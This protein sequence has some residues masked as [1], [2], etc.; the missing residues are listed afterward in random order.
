MKKK[1]TRILIS[2]CVVAMLMTCIGVAGFADDTVTYTMKAGDNVYSVCSRLGIDFNA[3]QAWITSVNN[4]TN[5]NNLKVGKVLILPTFNTKT[6]VTRAAQ[7]LANLKGNSNA[8]TNTNTNTNTGGITATGLMSGDTIVSYLVNHV[9]QSGQTVAGVCSA[10]GV[11]F[12]ANSDKIKTLSG[13]TSW[14]KIPV[15]TTVVI[16]SL[17]VPTGASYTAIVAHIVRS[18]ETVGSICSNYG[19]VFAKVQEQLKALNSTN[20]LN[21]I[22]VGQIFYLPVSS[23]VLGT[24]SGTITYTGTG[25]TTTGTTTVTPTPAT[26]TASTISG[27]HG[28]FKLQ[29]NGVDATTAAAGQTVTIVAY[30]EAGYVVNTVTIKSTDGKQYVTPSGMSFVMPNYPVTIQVTFTKG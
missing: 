14:N 23:T 8:N 18:G 17:T 27:S 6:E 12:A 20:N 9:L 13:I 28:S 10:Y 30:P 5:Y 1:A 4:I 21:V 11:S 2:I 22:K 19:L 7:V 15:G 29:V 16:P 3:N 26:S 24:T 25:T